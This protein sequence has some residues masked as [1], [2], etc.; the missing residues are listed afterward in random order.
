MQRDVVDLQ[1][2]LDTALAER[3]SVKRSLSSALMLRHAAH[4]SVGGAGLSTASV[5]V[6]A[7]AAAAAA[8]RLSMP[9]GDGDATATPARADASSAGRGDDTAGGFDDASS[10]FSPA[11][12]LQRCVRPIAHA[13]RGR[14]ECL[15]GRRVVGGSWS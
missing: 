5:A 11:D 12:T 13:V 2:A 1:A 4:S 6:A 14:H 9:I 7:A 10:T 3:E 8:P 15:A